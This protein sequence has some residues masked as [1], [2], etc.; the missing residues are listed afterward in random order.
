[1]I[2]SERVGGGPLRAINNV[3]FKF[4]DLVHHPS[5]SIECDI[6]LEGVRAM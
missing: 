3:R 4:A 1:M 6:G 2:K 5:V